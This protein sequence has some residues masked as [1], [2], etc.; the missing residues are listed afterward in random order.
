MIRCLVVEDQTMLQQML[1]LLLQQLPQL[2]LMQGAGSVAE[3]MCACAKQTPDLLIL[4][5]ALPDGD[6]LAIA[7]HLHT[8]NPAARVIV[9]SSFASTVE[10]PRELRNQLVAILDKT[11]AFEDL[12]SAITPLLQAKTH[13]D[14]ARDLKLATLTVREQ[15]VLDLLGRGLSSLEIAAKLDISLPTTSTHRRNICSKLGLSGAAL[16]RQA[17]L[18]NQ[19]HCQIFSAKPSQNDHLHKTT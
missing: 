8:V 13:Q 2:E 6:G 7:H 15:Q 3:A 18:W 14:D 9:L 4:D 17:V 11:R 12:I 5:I 1:M 19:S 16:V 10:W